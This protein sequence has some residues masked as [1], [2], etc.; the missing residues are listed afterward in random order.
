MSSVDNADESVG[1]LSLVLGL[2]E[3]L[4]SEQGGYFGFKR[5]ADDIYPASS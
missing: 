2:R 1:G 3:L 5:G 4:V